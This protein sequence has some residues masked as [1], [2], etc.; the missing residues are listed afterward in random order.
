MDAVT[1]K[2]IRASFVNATK[3]EARRLGMPR[4]LLERSW[5]DSA[6]LAWLD[7]KSPLSGYLVMPTTDGLVGVQLRR[8][9][10]DGSS[11]RA[12]MCALCA[13][14][15]SAQGAALMVAPRAGKAGRDGNTV[16]LEMCAA[17][18][19]EQYARG[20]LKPPG[21]NFVKETLSVD[22]RVDRLRRNALAFV[23]R[24]MS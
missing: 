4:D 21:A 6:Q 2:E 14:T 22:E 13:T 23:H 5:E 12:R 18:E 17:L 11:R 8:S 9:A 3:G 20:L 15:H 19:C 24:V 7:P 10:N 1:E 16:G